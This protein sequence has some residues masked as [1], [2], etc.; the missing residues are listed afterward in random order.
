MK[1]TTS[2]AIAMMALGLAACGQGGGAKADGMPAAGAVA[3]IE[4]PNLSAD[5][6]ALPR[7]AGDSPAIQRI[8]AE[9]DRLDA[10]ATNSAT[11]C[12]EMARGGQGGWA[13]SVTR[14]MIGPAYVALREHLEIYCGGAYP[15]NSQTAVTYDLATG[16][17]AD[18]VSLLPG[19]GLKQD[20][21]MADMPADY[22]YSIRSP[23][24]EALYERKMTETATDR[25]WL[26][27]CRDV[28]KPQ[29]A[30]DMGQGFAVWAD[31]EHGA[32][33]V[34]A[35]YVHAVQACG[36]SVYLTEADL[37]A[38]GADAHL[39]EALNAAKAAGAWAPKEDAEAA[40]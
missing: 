21:A 30:D 1:T 38:A 13:R 34:S 7:L 33:A 35:D 36:G 22:V 10:A 31:A 11:D 29:A 5:I 23:R 20:E 40:E 3:L 39:I 27:Q 4:K 24:L 9:L 8:N 28:W 25:E 32:V 37:R 26:E 12:S 15:S 19:L 2:A 6:E 16:A 14:P 17:R 18:W